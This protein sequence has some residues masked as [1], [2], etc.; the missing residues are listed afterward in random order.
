MSS[1]SQLTLIWAT[2]AMHIAQ[3]MMMAHTATAILETVTRCAPL[4]CRSHAISAMALR[5]LNLY[6]RHCRASSAGSRGFIKSGSIE[7][8]YGVPGSYKPHLS[9]PSINHRPHSKF[10]GAYR[11]G[12]SIKQL[13][14]VCSKVFQ[15]SHYY[16]KRLN[17]RTHL[18]L[19]VPAVDIEGEEGGHSQHL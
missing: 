19:D 15:W 18:G 3:P 4:A 8:T 7:Y 12:D 11:R 10:Q 5:R 6:R 16:H 1:T 9:M 17:G 13:A 2:C 14:D